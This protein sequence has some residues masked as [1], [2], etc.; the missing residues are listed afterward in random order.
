MKTQQN[1]LRNSAQNLN[2]QPAN[3]VQT[4]MLIESASAKPARARSISP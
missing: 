2:H 4:E 1:T 3:D